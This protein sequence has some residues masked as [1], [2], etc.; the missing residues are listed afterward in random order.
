MKH[1]DNTPHHHVPLQ[2]AVLY[3]HQ[4]KGQADND[5]L[6]LSP[7]TK[8]LANIPFNSRK[9]NWI[10][11]RWILFI[12]IREFLN[13]ADRKNCCKM[14]TN[15][16]LSAICQF[17]LFVVSTCLLPLL[18]IFIIQGLRSAARFPAVIL[19]G[20]LTSQQLQKWLRIHI[21]GCH[22]MMTGTELTWRQRTL[23]PGPS[24]N[25]P[26]SGSWTSQ[27]SV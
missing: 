20:I 27:L 3:V 16:F 15:K 24:T 1:G 11:S 22:L 13:W 21:L 23:A 9:E 14:F 12:N 6:M 8:N 2:C 5:L 17:F 25:N 10:N 4:H 18:F 19:R 7:K 26:L